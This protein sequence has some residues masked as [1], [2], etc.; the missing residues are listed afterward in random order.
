MKPDK[1]FAD[2]NIFLRYLTNDVPDQ[3]EAVEELF[4]SAAIGDILLITNSLVIAEIVW[5]LES[6][7]RLSR[8]DIQV[9]V[10]AILN[11]PGLEVVDSDLIFQTI[12]WYKDK[13]VD[14]LDGYNGAW[15]LSQ[16][17]KTA[18]TFDQKHF[19]RFEGI[20]VKAPGSISGNA[21]K[22]H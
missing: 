7:Y 4:R 6:Y 12:T 16:G 17:I 10:L 21:K 3:A 22:P 14:F 8:E 1:V 9:K 11:T 13:N 20:S 18:Y 2:T 19:S 15:L 5:T